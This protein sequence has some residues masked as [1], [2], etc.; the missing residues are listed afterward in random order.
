MPIPLPQLVVFDLPSISPLCGR[1]LSRC[2][3]APQ[4]AASVASLPYLDR[5]CVLASTMLLAPASRTLIRQPIRGGQALAL[6]FLRCHRHRQFA[7][8]A[9]VAVSPHR[10]N[11]VH[12]HAAAPASP[13]PTTDRGPK[14][15]YESLVS[16][17][18]FKDDPY[19]HETLEILQALFERLDSYQPP[20]VVELHGRHGHL[21]PGFFSQMTSMFAS[22]PSTQRWEA[23]R[24]L[25]LWGDVGTGKTTVMDLFYNS[26]SKERKRRVHFNSFMKDIHS[27]IHQLRVRDG[28]TSDPIPIIST[29]LTNQAWLL[30]FDELQVTNIV[31]AMLLRRLFQH[32]LD[33][34]VVIVTTSNRPPDDLY[35]NGIQRGSFLPTIALLK[36]RCV[37]HCLDSGVDYRKQKQDTFSVY[38]SPLNTDSQSSIE[39]LWRKITKGQPV[40]PK[41]IDF[42]GRSFV[43]P[44]ACGRAG[45]ISFDD[46]CGKAHSAS[47]YLE[48]VKHIDTLVLTDVPAMTLQHR[49]EARRFITLLDTL[50][51]NKVRLAMS[52]AKSITGLFALELTD[53]DTEIS[54]EEIKI[55]ENMAGAEEVFAFRRAVSRLVEMKGRNWLGDDFIALL[56][57]DES[58]Q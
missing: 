27:R 45:K 28:Y 58:S 23:P 2:E 17:G 44:E 42:L 14:H 49:N 20:P 24:G 25:Y 21:R 16:S 22:A 11:P 39:S 4:A 55:S 33:R 19:Q 18:R 7:S 51:D 15:L 41:K 50:Y 46:I 43:I 29:D 57:S 13:L 47:D 35:L 34:G 26:I 9:A 6:G 1:L 38:F 52:S 5:S 31:D 3:S 37:V 12:P 54:V 48:L 40:A 8:T 32:L 10:H 30:C 56:N 53:D 36:E